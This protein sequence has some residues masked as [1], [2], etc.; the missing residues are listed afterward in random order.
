MTCAKRLNV[1]SLRHRSFAWRIGRIG[2]LWK[3]D[4]LGLGDGAVLQRF[5]RA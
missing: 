4:R 2:R 5:E 3:F 1:E